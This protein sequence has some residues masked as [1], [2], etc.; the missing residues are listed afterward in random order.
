MV[1]NDDAKRR[2]I[3]PGERESNCGSTGYLYGVLAF[4]AWGLLPIFWKLLD[5]LPAE[6]IL[7][8]RIIWSFVFLSCILLGTGQFEKV[9]KSLGPKRNRLLIL[10]A[11]LIISFNWFTYIWA[12]NSNHVVEASLGYFIN[13]LA[14]ALLSIFVVKE[15]LNRGQYAALGLASVGVATMTGLYGR[16]PWVALALAVSFALYGLIKKYLQV[17]S[18]VSLALETLLVMPVALAYLIYGALTGSG[19]LLR[20]PP[21]TMVLIPLSGVVTA[22]PL[23]WFTRSTQLIKFSTVGF[24]QYIAPTMTLI[25]GIFLFKEEFSPGHFVSFSFIWAALLVYTFST[26]KH[27]FSSTKKKSPRL[28]KQPAAD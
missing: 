22:T 18:L 13:P 25:L 28:E 12:V 9:K 14:V 6:E 1:L 23:I 4:T 3:M 5:A 15:R 2:D 24:L 20:L 21:L 26:F 11:S 10:A 17:E 8:N 7:A 27:P 16:V 19:A